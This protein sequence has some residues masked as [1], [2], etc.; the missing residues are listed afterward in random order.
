M[1]HE[2]EKEERSFIREHIVPRKNA[3]KVLLTILATVGLALLFGAIAG[4]S[5]YVSQNVMKANT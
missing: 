3:K 5:F 2:H 4:V 1:E